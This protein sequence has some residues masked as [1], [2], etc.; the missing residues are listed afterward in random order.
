MLSCLNKVLSLF[1]ILFYPF[2]GFA[3]LQ[4]L[5]YKKSQFKEYLLSLTINDVS[6]NE[7]YSCLRD[8]KNRVFI[9][10]KDL[11]EIGI[12]KEVGRIIYREGESYCDLSS[13]VGIKYQ[14]DESEL[15]LFISLPAKSFKENYID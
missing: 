3:E 12:R 13:V 2:C 15:K 4:T 10:E 7:I 5:H 9:K 11:R 8:D 6:K 1:I 14:L